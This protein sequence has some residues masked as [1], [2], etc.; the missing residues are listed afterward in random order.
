MQ[1]SRS[2]A[3]G[4]CARSAR[5]GGGAEGTVSTGPPPDATGVRRRLHLGQ[6]LPQ[7][8]Q[9]QHI[10]RAQSP[11][12]PEPAQ[13]GVEAQPPPVQQQPAA[14]APTTAPPTPRPRPVDPSVAQGQRTA[15]VTGAISIIFGV[16]YLA[17]VQFMDMRGGELLPPPPEAF[18]P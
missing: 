10:L 8:Q 4:G 13:P 7:K 1:G 9:P 17:L 2:G 3:P 18:G 5:W 6:Q 16:L 12:S 14:A 11:D 15:I